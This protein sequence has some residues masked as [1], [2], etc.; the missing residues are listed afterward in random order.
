LE[1]HLQELAA[2]LVLERPDEYSEAVLGKPPAEY[3]RWILSNEHWG[4]AVPVVARF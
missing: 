1:H 2:R 3:A 4:G